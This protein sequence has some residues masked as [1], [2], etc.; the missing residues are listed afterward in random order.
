MPKGIEATL[1]SAVVEGR[2]KPGHRLSENQLAEAFG[3]SRTLV[4]E[5]LTRLEARNI[6]MVKPRKGWFVVEPS[7]EEAAE[8]YATRRILEYG[9]LI[10]SAPFTAAQIADLQA[11]IDEERKA[12]DASDKT[13]LT[14][15]MGDFH[16]RIVKQSGNATLVETMRTLA[17]RT[18]L[19]SLRYQSEHNAL[20]SHKDHVEIFEAIARGDMKT[21]AR[22]SFEH[23]EDVEA[24]I[25]ID[26]SPDAIELLKNTLRL[27][28]APNGRG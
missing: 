20:A 2:I 21:A 1:L 16:V 17:A 18:N 13:R 19:I 14:Y 15:L 9:F 12:V 5:A 8:V 6:V 26:T 4:R 7:A 10:N 11:H 23:L 27:D 24:G 28:E 22:L 25:M 3:V